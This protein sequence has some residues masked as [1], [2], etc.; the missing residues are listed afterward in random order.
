MAPHRSTITDTNTDNSTYEQLMGTDELAWY[1][2]GALQYRHTLTRSCTRSHSRSLTPPTGPPSPTP[3]QTIALTSSSWV[4]M[5]SHGTDAGHCS[6]GTPSLAHAL[7]LT[8]AHIVAKFLLLTFHEM[9]EFERV[10]R[11]LLH[12]QE[13]LTQLLSLIARRQRLL[14][15]RL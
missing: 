7:A 2:C 3:T 12:T 13:R 8:L 14:Q 6:I 10:V 11:W 1:R 15:D 4:R 9:A 5:S